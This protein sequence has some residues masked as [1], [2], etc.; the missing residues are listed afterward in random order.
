MKRSLLSFLTALAGPAV[1]LAFY[2]TVHA[3]WQAEIAALQGRHEAA[4]TTL[5][6]TREAKS[7]LKDFHAED[8][9]LDAELDRIAELLPGSLDAEEE[10]QQV[11]RL[12][13]AAGLAIEPP[14]ALPRQ[15]REF[16]GELPV[17]FRVTADRGELEAL[18]AALEAGAPLH[19]VTKAGFDW[20][21]QGRRRCL[22]EVSGL[23]LVPPGG[24]PPPAGESYAL[25]T[26]TTVTS[27]GGSSRA[28]VAAAVVEQGVHDLQRRAVAH[29]P[30]H[31]AGALEAVGVALAVQRLEEAVRAEDERA[32]GRQRGTRGRRRRAP[33]RGRAGGRGA[34]SP[35]PGPLHDQRDRGGRRWRAAPRP[36]PGRAG[37]GPGW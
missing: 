21:R 3:S 5:Q 2:V 22:V 26:A 17:S 6:E 1:F 13:S 36:S 11:Q 30:Q 37:S 34:R 9:H 18:I 29:R 15:G 7:N 33:G 31:L 20:S 4:L 27:S 19:R 14:A 12:A 24:E 32:A 35:S 28:E 25:L 16:Y 8:E 23:Y 10:I